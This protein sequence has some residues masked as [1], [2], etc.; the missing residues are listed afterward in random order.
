MLMMTA[1]N[2]DKLANRKDQILREQIA[3][4]LIAEAE[5]HPKWEVHDLLKRLAKEIQEGELA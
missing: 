2:F 1:D 4:K 3:A 5:S